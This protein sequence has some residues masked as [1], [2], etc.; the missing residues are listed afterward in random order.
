MLK[1]YAE[2][3]I[4]MT[5]GAL[6]GLL[7]CGNILIPSLFPF[8]VLS[9]FIVT[10]GLA[11]IIG[12]FLSPVTKKLFHTSG[13]TGSVILLGLCGGFPVGAKG[14]ATL[15]NEE[16]ID[17]NTAKA[18]SLFLVG[19][20]PAFV[21]CVVGSTLYHSITTGFI[22]WAIQIVSQIL[23]GIFACRRL[24]YTPPKTTEIKKLPLSNAIVESTE[25]GIHSIFSMCGMV[26]IFS[27]VFGLCEDLHIID[28]LI[29]S[30]ST[31]GVPENIG[32]SILSSLWEVTKGCNTCCDFSAPLWLTSFALGWGGICVHF[33]IYSLTTS[34]NVS[35]IKFTLYRLAQ[36]VMSAIITAVV[37]TFYTPSQTTYN[38]Q[39]SSPIVCNNYIGS[40]ALVMMCII[41]TLSVTQKGNSKISRR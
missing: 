10:S 8:M 25:S 1:N 7:Y 39:T 30:L 12:R 6:Q 33:Q 5:T 9:S 35:K 19:G 17:H 34:I 16:K 4:L 26:V 36:G 20:G 24:E 29:N 23:L 18:L 40:I 15:Y 31:V 37:F 32:K 38:A 11:E 21:V 14:I 27:S 2:V 28:Y 13:A 3:V 41:F 22:L